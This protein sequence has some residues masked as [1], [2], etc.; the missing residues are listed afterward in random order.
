MAI[1][2]LS[3]DNVISLWAEGREA[4]NHKNTL[5]AIDGDLFSYNL[6][7]GHRTEGG[8]CVVADFTA[9]GGSYHS[10]TTSC[11]VGRA[12]RYADMVMHPMVWA[13]SPLSKEEVPF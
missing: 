10:Q 6:K 1:P 5:K 3:N 11:H 4:R 9:G 13:T 2:V 8:Q 12:K 7:I